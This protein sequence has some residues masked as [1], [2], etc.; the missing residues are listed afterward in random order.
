M[1]GLLGREHAAD[2]AEVAAHH[3]RGD[4]VVFGVQP[5]A[6]A[7]GDEQV[8]LHALFVLN[9]GELI[10]QRHRDQQRARD[11]Q[12]DDNDQQLFQSIYTPRSACLAAPKLQ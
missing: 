5:L 7:R 3:L 12:H 1:F 10:A 11:E 4:A 9:A 2:A 6:L 8:H